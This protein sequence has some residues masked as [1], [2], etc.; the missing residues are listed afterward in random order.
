MILDSIKNSERYL[1]LNPRFQKVFDFLKQHDAWTLPVGR[2]DIDGDELFV[3]VSELDLKPVEEAL[4]EVHDKYIDI[5][6]V[7]GGEELFGWSERCDCHKAQG[8]FDA[9][10]DVQFF[11]DT[12]QTV[13][14]VREGQFTILFPEDA[15]APMLGKGH[16]RKLIF[17]VLR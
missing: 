1:S 14:A 11:T 10:R 12:P 5:Q 13:Y 6:V 16:V 15:H 3:N 9:S 7:F 8:E 2:N 17:K 4:L